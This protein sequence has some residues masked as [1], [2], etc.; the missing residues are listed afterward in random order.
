MNSINPSVLLITPFH[1]SQRGNTLTTRR[2]CTGL[3]RQGLTAELLSLEDTDYQVKLHQHL[4]SG[5]FNMVHAFNGLYLAKIMSSHPQLLD[6]PLIA[7]LTGTDINLPENQEYAA[8]EPV[9]TAAQY[10]VVFH[11][12]FKNRLLSHRPSLE[13]KVAVIPQGICL[14]SAPARKP[15]DFGIPVD[16]TVFLLPTGLRPVKNLG[17]ALDG[18]EPLASEDSRVRLLIMGPVIDKTY[19]LHILQRIKALPWVVYIGEVSHT[20]ISGVFTLGDVVMNCSEAEGQPQAALEAMSLGVPAILSDVPGNRSIIKNG[21]EGFYIKTSRDLYQ[22]ARILLNRPAL[23]QEMGQAAA[24]LVK[25]R[26]DY[27][28]EI[29]QHIEIY[30]KALG[31]SRH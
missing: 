7:T 3:T 12:D 16:S 20:E 22:A 21:R 31:V 6:Y 10:I 4:G 29:R 9:F 8:L 2:I 26:F 15:Q 28:C 14:P 19:G 30:K 17:L 25:A 13:E 27:T 23:R 5:R 11:E 1:K 24:E 18:L